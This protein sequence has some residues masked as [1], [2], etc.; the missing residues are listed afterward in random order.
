MSEMNTVAAH[1]DRP[2]LADALIARLAE[3]GIDRRSVTLEHLAALDQ[4]HVRGHPATLELADALELPKRA[5][6]LDL[7]SGI[8]G[9][10]RV[11]ASAY[12]ARVTALDLTPA[13]CEANRALNQLV[14]LTRRITVLEGDATNLP[15][16]NATFDR[17]VTIHASMNI[18]RKRTMYR[19]A[20][21]VLKPGGRFGF[22]DVVAGP[23]GRPD[24]PL[25]WATQA[26]DSFLVSPSTMSEIAEEVGFRNRMF[27]DVTNQA[28]NEIVRQQEAAAAGKAAGDP[29]PLQAGDILMGPKASDKQRNL[30]RALKEGRIGL[31]MAVFEK[32]RS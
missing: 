10:A 5:K 23:A 8:G 20:Y 26:I 2:L 17:V 22:Y 7:G 18:D 31:T 27:R 11:L 28:R 30:R 21:R 19:E 14:G 16:E 29:V 12:D 1:Y 4:M 9:P 25:P 13:L 32:P 15:F 6:V 24:F 3:H